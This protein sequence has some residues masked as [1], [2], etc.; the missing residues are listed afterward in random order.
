MISEKQMKHILKVAEINKARYALEGHNKL[1]THQSDD[2]KIKIGLAN[3]GERNGMWKGDNVGYGSLHDWV[4]CHLNKPEK[5]ELCLAEPP[6]DLSNKS[7]L[8]KRELDDW[9]L[10]CRKCH[11]IKDGRY[12]KLKEGLH[13]VRKMS[14]VQGR[15]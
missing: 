13:N 15:N 4:K 14:K 11:M 6:N 10:L 5:C 12:A 7:G 9:E 1:G 3:S 8:Y 2:T